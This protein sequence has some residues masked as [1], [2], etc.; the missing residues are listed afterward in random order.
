MNLVSNCVGS[1]WLWHVVCITLDLVSTFWNIPT[2]IL[3]FFY[4]FSYQIL[5]WSIE[6]LLFGPSICGVRRTTFANAYG[7]KKWGAMENMSGNIEHSGNTLGTWIEHSGNILG[8]REKWKKNSFFIFVGAWAHNTPC[9]EHP[10]TH[11]GTLLRLAYPPGPSSIGSKTPFGLIWM[12]QLYPG[13]WIWYEIGTRSVIPLCSWN[14]FRLYYYFF[15][16][17]NVLNIFLPLLIDFIIF[18]LFFKILSW[19]FMC[20][21]FAMPIAQVIIF[22]HFEYNFPYLIYQILPHLYFT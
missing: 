12:R 18:D 4:I 2:L 6:F 3:E 22:L 10:T 8:T 16:H 7:I 15:Y 9:K 20:L 19:I 5:F 21:K 13:Y 17:K 1:S 11:L 14:T